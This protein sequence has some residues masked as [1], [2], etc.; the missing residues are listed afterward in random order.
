MLLKDLRDLRPVFEEAS[1]RESIAKLEFKI[2]KYANEENLLGF[3]EVNVRRITNSV[4][5][6]GIRDL[7]VVDRYFRLRPF[8][9]SRKVLIDLL[10]RYNGFLDSHR[11][12]KDHLFG[13]FLVMSHLQDLAN[14]DEERYWRVKNSEFEKIEKTIEELKD[15]MDSIDSRSL[16]IYRYLEGKDSKLIKGILKMARSNRLLDVNQYLSLKNDVKNLQEIQV[17]QEEDAQAML[18]NHY[19]SLCSMFKDNVSIVIERLLPYIDDFNLS[20]VLQGRIY[21][22]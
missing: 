12:P 15:K 4:Y 3:Q 13:F 10:K 2:A 17:S 16:M 18:E 8:E 5:D 6:F 21:Q 1:N 14:K 19:E 11:D 7:D 20:D 9:K 22:N